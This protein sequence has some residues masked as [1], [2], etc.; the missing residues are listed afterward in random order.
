MAPPLAPAVRAALEEIRERPEDDTPR[1]MLA[2]WLTDHGDELDRVRATLLR[3]QCELAR[4]DPHDPL[5]LADG[6][7]LADLIL[8]HAD[9]LVGLAHT[10][11][12]T[13]DRGLQQVKVTSGELDTL[14]ARPDLLA[15]TSR[16][17]FSRGHMTEETLALAGKL[18]RALETVRQLI[19]ETVDPAPAWLAALRGKAVSR[20]T[21]LEVT[22]APRSSTDPDYLLDA[23]PF[24][25]LVAL[26]ANHL[27]LARLATGEET[28]R[29]R[30]LRLGL[31]S[32]SLDPLFASRS[33][34]HLER[35]SLTSYQQRQLSFARRDGLPALRSLRCTGLLDGGAL[36]TDVVAAPF[37]PRLEELELTH[38]ALTSPSLRSLVEGQ[39]GTQLCKLDLSQCHIGVSGAIL[40]AWT[41]WPA[42]ETLLLRRN[43]LDDE[44]AGHL[45]PGDFHALRTLDVAGC[46]LG[47][48]GAEKLAAAPWLAGLRYL[49]LGWNGIGPAGLRLILRRNWPNLRGL[50]LDENQLG[51]VGVRVLTGPESLAPNLVGLHLRG[52]RITDAGAAWL[53]DW[54]LLG[55]MRVLDLQVNRIGDAGGRALL[56][57]QYT[58]SLQ[59]LALG[60]NDLSNDLRQAFR[61]RFG[62]RV[63]LA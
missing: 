39:P 63:T 56:E 13:W 22:G 61:D 17:T 12:A 55:Q 3:E 34:P 40:L 58:Q 10:R 53:A 38:L 21:H 49:D 20:L 26:R 9:D 4:R 19:L 54:P 41:R 16:V 50:N 60:I 45:A 11:R 51:D 43:P 37:W 23:G 59:W 24:P 48:S 32:E 62:Y 29:L 57:S 6:V 52:N 18:R 1:L 27:D 25:D 44:G 42:L 2:D 47:P 35:L 15:W 30:E 7:R 33:L 46:N 8:R 31:W 28:P 5:R 36:M 14:L